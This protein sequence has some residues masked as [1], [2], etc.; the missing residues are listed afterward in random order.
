MIV[1]E[2]VASVAYFKLKVLYVCKVRVGHFAD[3]ASAHYAA[4]P[5]Y[6]AVSNDAKY[7][8]TFSGGFVV[9]ADYGMELCGAAVELYDQ[10]ANSVRSEAR[11]VLLACNCK[12]MVFNGQVGRWTAPPLH[13]AGEVE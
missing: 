6:L 8:G 11:S 3:V 10:T 5:E 2:T 1:V 9:D 7:N 12:L 4:A 13:S